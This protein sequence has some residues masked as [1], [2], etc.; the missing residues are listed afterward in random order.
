MEISICIVYYMIYFSRSPIFLDSPY[1][2]YV[3]ENM[4][5]FPQTVVVVNAHDEDSSH[6]NSFQVR[7]L[8]K[9][10]DKDTFRVNAST[11][12]ITVHRSLDRERQSD[13]QL[14]IVAMDT[15]TYIQICFLF[16]FISIHWISHCIKSHRILCIVNEHCI[17]TKHTWLI[18][19]SLST[20]TC[21]HYYKY[22]C[23]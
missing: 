12:E 16:F 6:S 1:I 20:F 8:M 15:G 3:R 11:G 5:D 10:G 23:T 19:F 2:A 18:W 22:I 13:Y 9:D 17:Q 4:E 14:T 21:L 7:Y